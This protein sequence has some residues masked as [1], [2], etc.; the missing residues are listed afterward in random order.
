MKMKTVVLL[1]AV[2]LTLAGWPLYGNAE[3]TPPPI[4]AEE[5]PEVLTRG[6]VHEAFAEP[7]DLQFQPGLVAPAQPPVNIIENPPTDRPVGTQF[8]WVPGYWAWDSERNGYIWVSGCWRATPPN[9]SWVSGYWAKVVQGWQWVPGFWIPVTNAEQVEYLPAPPAIEEAQPPVAPLDS[10]NIWVPSCWYWYQGQYIQRPGYWLKAKSNWVWM[11]SHY[12]W[13]PRGYVF[14]K[15]YWDYVLDSRGVLFSPVYFPRKF[16]EKPGFSYSLS[17]VVDTGNLQFSLFTY[18][19]YGHYYFGDY[20]DDSYVSIGIYPWFEFERYHTWYDPIYEYNRWHFHKTDPGWDKH[21]RD[22]Y[23]RRRADKSL[24]PPRTYNAMKNRLVGLP[25]PQR[26]SFQTAKPLSVFIA[27]K[28]SPLK[29]G[30]VKPNAKEKLSRQST[31]VQKFRE[32]RRRWESQANKQKTAPSSGERKVPR[33]QPERVKI[34]ASP[35]TGERH[36]SDIFKKKPPGRPADEKKTETKNSR[37]T[38]GDRGK[39]N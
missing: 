5:Q 26:R 31:N 25:E 2:L 35:V 3:E 20:Y 8:V 18:P 29:F 39:N 30:N 1:M 32:D 17:I 33:T 24:R 12:V 34:P 11:P 23:N 7:V 15:G 21:E 16:Y 38:K 37:R 27:D 4:P 36:W 19:R 28:K 6:P 9:M 14:V 13:T 10:D 22:E